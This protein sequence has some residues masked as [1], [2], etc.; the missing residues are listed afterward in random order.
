MIDE[1]LQ[2]LPQ[3]PYPDEELDTASLV[4]YQHIYSNYQGGGVSRYGCF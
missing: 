4:V 3:E 2:Y 1:G